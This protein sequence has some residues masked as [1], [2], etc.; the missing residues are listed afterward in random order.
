MKTIEQKFQFN[1][2]AVT[3][4]NMLMDSEKHSAFT[5][6]E[7]EIS[8]EVDGAFTAYNG[9]INGKNVEL[10]NGKKIVQ[11]WTCTDFPHDHFSTLTFN[12][13]DNSNGCELHFT[14]TNVPDNQYDAINEGWFEH[15]WDKMEV[16][17]N[18]II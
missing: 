3:I 17:A 10:V 13:E 11:P 2:S 9:Y 18:E 1:A 14:Q 8:A 4:Y 16:Y 5:E 12:L 15:Y 6:S 7:C